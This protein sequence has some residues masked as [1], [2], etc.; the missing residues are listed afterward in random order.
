LIANFESGGGQNGVGLT[1]LTSREF[2]YEAERLGGAHMPRNQCRVGFSLLQSLID[3]YGY[4][5]GIGAYNAG[6]GNRWSVR[7]TYTQSVINKDNAWKKRL[8]AVR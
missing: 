7:W 8:E 5:G 1:Q 3:D 2:V 4:E 6:P